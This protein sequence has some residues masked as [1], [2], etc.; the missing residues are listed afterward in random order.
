[1]GFVGGNRGKG[2]AERHEELAHKESQRI[3]YLRPFILFLDAASSTRSTAKLI[4]SPN[5]SVE[6]STFSVS[7]RP[8]PTAGY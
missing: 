5:E 3:C 7:P 2:A 8:I 1:M 4:S 6:L